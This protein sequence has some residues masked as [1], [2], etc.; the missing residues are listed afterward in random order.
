MMFDIREC[1][2]LVEKENKTVSD[3]SNIFKGI[4]DAMLNGV[5]PHDTLKMLTDTIPALFNV[6]SDELLDEA[7]RITKE[8]IVLVSN[9]DDR[10]LCDYGYMLINIKLGFAPKTVESALRIVENR[11]ATALQKYVAFNELSTEAA[12]A[13]LY[14]KARDYALM[15]IECLKDITKKQRAVYEINAYGNLAAALSYTQRKEEYEKA[16]EQIFERLNSNHDKK[17]LL[18]LIASIY[19]DISV[20]DIRLKGA[21][22]EFVND[23]KKS[24]ET[25]I[26][27]AN[28]K[29]IY[30]HRISD[31]TRALEKMFEAG[32]YEECAEICKM[33]IENGDSFVGNKISIYT[34]IRK[35]YEVSETLI[36][37]EEY[38]NAMDRYLLELEKSAER[39][40][41]LL[42][43]LVREE[44][45]IRDISDAYGKLK[46]M[47]ETDS[48]T[49]TYN[50]PSFERS[51]EE[52][53]N[54]HKEGSL[55]FIDMDGLK[56]TNDKYGHEFGD[57]MLKT[58]VQIFN[59][60]IDPER[61]RLYRYAGDEFILVTSRDKEKTEILVSDILELFKQPFRYKERQIL[62]GFSYGISS[63][64]EAKESCDGKD[65]ISE[66]VKI[67]D[68][69][70]YECK[71][72]RKAKNPS[73]FRD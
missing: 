43:H 50:R 73:I 57:F 31:D 15:E 23:Y 52:Y 26:R 28:P 53:L 56:Y 63:Y 55:V 45:K 68:A 10:V 21:N 9:E 18:G 61:E 11:N 49:V 14:E 44:F 46:T 70:M 22:K 62:I 71:K 25:Y 12:S 59:N 66:A 3:I 27:N 33:I 13:G 48:L 72:Q 69:R 65:T 37:L 30:Y 2:K 60:V 39:S 42:S 20:S 36:P 58:F 35:L 5:N 7:I 1:Q 32:F 29:N 8:H 51:A 19:I 34:L 41:S 17:E 24:M 54:E 16:K 38:E 47:Y 6:D 4:N 64:I 40:K 67:A